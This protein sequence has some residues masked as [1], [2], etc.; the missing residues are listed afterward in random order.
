MTLR[1]EAR[2]TGRVHVRDDELLGARGT[3]L[4]AARPESVE[5]IDGTPGLR[6]R[7]VAATRRSPGPRRLVRA[8]AGPARLTR[9]RSPPPVVKARLGEPRDWA[10]LGL[11]AFTGLLFFRPQDLITPLRVLHLAEI[12]ALFAL[13]ALI[14]GPPEPRPAGDAADAGAGRR[15]R[16]RVRDPGDG[17]VL[18]VDGRRR[19]HVHRALRQGGADLRADGEHADL[20]AGACEQFTWLIVIASGYIGVP[21]R[22]RLRARH[23]PVENGRVQGSVG[24]MFKNPN[25]L[26]LNMVAVLPLAV[27]LVLRPVS[28]LKRGPGRLLRGADARRDRRVTVALG[29]GRPR[30]DGPGARRPAAQT[31]AWP[32]LRR[33]LCRRCWPC[34]CCRRP[35]GSAWRA[36]PTRTSTR[37][38]RARRGRCCCASRSTRSSR[39]RSPV[40]A[41]GS[42]RTTTPR[43][44]KKRGARATTWCCRSPPSSAS[45]GWPSSSIW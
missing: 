34:R 2:G 39:T 43:G 16:L 4:A 17:P 32:R 28:M 38:V 37:P 40:S 14:S 6:L 18:R 41:P 30:R 24:G 29:H 13:G 44:A 35:T 5:V 25:D 27:F 9:R 15:P 33:G 42:S 20:A 10:F 12:A 3:V 45:P 11:M 19:R 7:H 8:V 22:A 23:Q 36:S 31:Q 1:P 21:R 26:A